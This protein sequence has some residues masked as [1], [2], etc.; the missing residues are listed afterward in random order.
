MKNIILILFLLLTSLITAQINISEFENNLKSASGTEQIEILNSLAAAYLKKQPN[1]SIEY[2]EKALKL[3]KKKLVS[4][5]I[6]A[7]LYNTLGAAHYIDKNYKKSIEY[8]EKELEIIEKSGLDVVT[9]NSCYNIAAIYK[10]LKNKKAKNYY[11][12]SLALAQ[13]NNSRDLILKI[14]EELAELMYDKRNYEESVNYYIEYFSAKNNQSKQKSEILASQYEQVLKQKVNQINIAEKDIKQ[15]ENQI[16]IAEKDIK[17]KENQIDIAEVNKQ[18]LINDTTQKSQRITSL[19]ELNNL[20]QIDIA[21]KNTI[22]HQAKIIIIVSISIIILI[23]C[24]LVIIFWL[25]R[26]IKKINSILT[27]KNAEINKHIIEINKKSKE[28][29]D[30]IVYASL[31]Q[32]AILPSTEILSELFVEHFILFRPRN[33]VSGDFYW[34]KQ[35]KNFLF[36]VAAD[37]TGHGVPGAF[38]SMLGITLLNDIVN[39]SNVDHPHETLNELRKRLKK[40]LHQTGQSGERQDGMDIAFCMIDLEQNTVEFAGAYNPFYLIRNKKLI[41]IKASRMPIGVYPFDDRDF[42]TTSIDLQPNDKFYIFS[43]GYSSQFGGLRGK[44]FKNKQFQEVLIQNT[45]KTMIDQKQI[46]EDTFDGWRGNLDQVDDVLVIGI[47]ICAPHIILENENKIESTQK[48][49]LTPEL[50]AAIS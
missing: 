47:N 8:Y 19:D 10:I 35:I 45:D 32:Q 21:Q 12:K 2:A 18:E 41:E 37:C 26:K 50:S 24:F 16:N 4:Q 33:I 46:L 11:L 28:I 7:N 27:Q 40:A 17:Q 29:T 14:Y 38:M 25:Y 48:S 3:N 20:Q 39:R 1:K 22:I 42:A 44:K 15:K 34:L 30:S 6:E 9:M 43:D 13:K 23:L 31:I 5:P 49:H 36:V